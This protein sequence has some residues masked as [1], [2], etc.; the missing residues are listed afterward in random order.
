MHTLK[1]IANVF[2][3]VNLPVVT[4][5]YNPRILLHIFPRIWN[6]IKLWLPRIPEKKPNKTGA[7]S[8]LNIFTTTRYCL[9]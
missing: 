2:H 8:D 1:P 5:K 6:T 4:Y 7:Q 9:S 3:T